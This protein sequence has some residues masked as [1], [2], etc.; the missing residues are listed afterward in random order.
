MSGTTMTRNAFSLATIPG[1]R[2]RRCTSYIGGPSS[3]LAGGKKF[4]RPDLERSHIIS[5]RILYE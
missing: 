2:M 3:E 5:L 4:A 1:D